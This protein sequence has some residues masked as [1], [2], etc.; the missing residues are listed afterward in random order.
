VRWQGSGR[1]KRG[2]NRVIYYWADAHGVVLMLMIYT[3]ADQID[4]T[5]DQLT[6]LRSVVEEEF[7]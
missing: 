3:K 4:L 5:R 6:I 7:K 2:G 1:G